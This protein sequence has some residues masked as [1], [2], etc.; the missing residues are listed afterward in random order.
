MAHGVSFLKLRSCFRH[1]YFVVASGV[2]ATT[3]LAGAAALVV[4]HKELRAC[5]GILSK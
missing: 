4:F 1:E 5:I 2:A 3:I